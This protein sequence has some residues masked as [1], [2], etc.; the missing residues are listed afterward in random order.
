MY[1]VKQWDSADQ[2]CSPLIIM[3]IS[4]HISLLHIF[5]GSIKF[6]YMNCHNIFK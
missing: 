6:H 4:F 3:W 5:T 2:V 1:K